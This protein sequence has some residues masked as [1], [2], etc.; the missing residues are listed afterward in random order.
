MIPFNRREVVFQKHLDFDLIRDGSCILYHKKDYLDKDK[1]WLSQKGYEV[2]EFHCH[3]WKDRHTMHTDLQD[4]LQFPY[5]GMNLDALNDSL[6]NRET[7]E[8]STGLIL[9]FYQFDSYMS[10]DEEYSLNLLDVL[11][12][13]SRYFLL[14]GEKLLVLIQVDNR[15]LE[16]Y[17]I[18]F[19]GVIWNFNERFAKS[20]GIPQEKMQVIG[21]KI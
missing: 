2:Y 6:K 12:N 15:A 8:N 21:K 16:I 9:I 1:N 4:K 10:K 13:C 18:S 20:R 5:Y 3:Q 19:N 11:N 7:V 14:F 17:P